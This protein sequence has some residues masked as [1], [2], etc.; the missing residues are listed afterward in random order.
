[1]HIFLS[2]A[3]HKSFFSFLTTGLHEVVSHALRLTDSSFI[4]VRSGPSFLF[5]ETP[6]SYC[7]PS[8][9]PC[10]DHPGLTRN[11]A[12]IC[13]LGTRHRSPETPIS[14]NDLSTTTRRW[15]TRQSGLSGRRNKIYTSKRTALNS[16]GP[17]PPAALRFREPAAGFFVSQG[18][19]AFLAF[20][21][22]FHAE[23]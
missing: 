23:S 22:S 12:P 17:K 1:M 21:C 6:F 15:M 7:Q 16:F 14:T 4:Q 9:E 10:L 20:R 19:A 2:S 3:I 5:A 8:G 13:A 11:F 18:K